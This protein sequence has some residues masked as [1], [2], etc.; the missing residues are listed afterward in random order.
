M[1]ACSYIEHKT[2]GISF[3]QYLV[4]WK[5]NVKLFALSNDDSSFIT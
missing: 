3:E 2:H 4:F 1:V 5:E